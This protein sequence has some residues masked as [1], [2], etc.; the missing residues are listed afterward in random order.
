MAI[1]YLSKEILLVRKN[2]LAYTFLCLNKLLFRKQYKTRYQLSCK[3]YRSRSAGFFISQLIWIR[4]VFNATCELI[5]IYQNTCMKYN[6]LNCINFIQGQVNRNFQ[7]VLNEKVPVGQVRHGISTA[8][9]VSLKP[10]SATM[11]SC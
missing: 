6:V 9:Q 1:M 2:R 10:P 4:T 11:V 7:L 3:H 5:I 8:L